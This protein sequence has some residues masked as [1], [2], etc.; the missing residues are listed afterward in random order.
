MSLWILST[1]LLIAV[2][3]RLAHSYPFK[4]E[5]N[6]N[7]ADFDGPFT[8]MDS[9]LSYNN[10]NSKSSYSDP[11]YETQNGG[12]FP[13]DPV[14]GYDGFGG[15]EGYQESNSYSP[16]ASLGGGGA[17]SGWV[18][19]TTGTGTMRLPQQRFQAAGELLRSEAIHE[20]GDSEGETQERNYYVDD[21]TSTPYGFQPGEL[22]NI[23]A[24]YEGGHFEGETQER[25]FRPAGQTDDGQTAES[26]GEEPA[27]PALSPDDGNPT[28]LSSLRHFLL[29]YKR[30]LLYPGTMEHYASEYT[31]GKHEREE[32]QKW[33]HGLY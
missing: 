23:E 1:W 3:G 24:F 11:R 20:D 32:L 33:R 2:F 9:T 7:E 25:G 30:G 28:V 6:P 19:R 5:W 17:S 12:Y 4:N 29:L 14:D 13:L 22:T 16:V 8:N 15:S 31:E 21:P 18:P 26:V 27:G 10:G